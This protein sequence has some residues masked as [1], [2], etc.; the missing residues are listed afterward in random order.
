[1]R[2]LG[3]CLALSLSLTTTANARNCPAPASEQ[4]E[5]YPTAEVLPENLLRM[6]IYFPRPMGI[7]EGLGNV[8]L[9]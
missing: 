2:S 9:L 5:I 3:V 6:Y 1:M 8:H 4:I 7:E